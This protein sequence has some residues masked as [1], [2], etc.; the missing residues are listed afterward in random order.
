MTPG[1]LAENEAI[2]KDVT[3]VQKDAGIL[4]WLRAV[5]E[6]AERGRRRRQARPR[7]GRTTVGSNRRALNSASRRTG[8][9]R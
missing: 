7:A 9:Q 3:T 1:G 5:K 8:N 6:A 2:D 4:W